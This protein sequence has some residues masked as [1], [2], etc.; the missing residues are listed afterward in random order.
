[1]SRN[2]KQ[3]EEVLRESEEHLTGGVE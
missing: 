3:A 1:M 2:I